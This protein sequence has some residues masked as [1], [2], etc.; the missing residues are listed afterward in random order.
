MATSLTRKVTLAFILFLI[1]VGSVSTF[2][3]LNGLSVVEEFEHL[4]EDN[5]QRLLK[6]ERFHSI[7]SRSVQEAR[8]FTAT[9]DVGELEEAEETLE[10]AQLL[11]ESIAEATHNNE[12][13]SV[14]QGFRALIA[15]RRTLVSQ[16]T[17]HIEALEQP[18]LSLE[19]REALGEE[20]EELEKLLEGA[21]E[22]AFSLV[23]LDNA[24][25][26][27]LLA[28]NLRNNLIGITITTLTCIIGGLAL[29]WLI[30]RN[31][32][33]PLKSLAEATTRLGSGSNQ[34]ISITSRDEIGQL[35]QA[36]NTAD[37]AIR[38]RTLALETEMSRTATAYRE[39]ES[40]RVAAETQL[41]TIEQQQAIIQDMSVPVLPVT[42]KILVMPL[43]GALDTTRIRQAQAQ[44][45]SSIQEY[46]ARQLILDITGV[47]LIDTQVAAGLI[48][49]MQAARLLGANIIL[50]GVRPEV[51]QS[52]VQLGI[53][54]TAIETRSTL[55]AAISHA[56]QQGK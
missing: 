24:Q 22:E 48:S 33:T 17:T 50:A 54:L 53:N 5:L 36:F 13:D 39:V 21:I 1:I 43:V 42:N 4:Q 44:A 49:I 37:Q 25:V 45:L 18:N 3:F 35:Q 56:L 2:T 7:L 28:A 40:A 23:E 16:L 19:Q 30:N 51:A 47:P 20:L 27:T 26:G 34:L 12:N 29:L 6:L 46:R 9:G 41:Q 8:V 11:L 10:E 32:V 14:E 15:N 52:L 31:I 55:Q 38:Q